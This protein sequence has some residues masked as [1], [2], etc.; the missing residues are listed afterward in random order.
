[1]SMY[2]LKMIAV[3]AVIVLVLSSCTKTDNNIPSEVSSAEQTYSASD[4]SVEAE[5][6]I[7]AQDF[8]GYEFK[9]IAIDDENSNPNEIWVEA[10]NGDILRDSIYFRNRAVEEKLNI[11][12]SSAM[13][14]VQ[15]SDIGKKIQTSIMTGENLFDIALPNLNGLNTILGLDNAIA[16]LES[17]PTLDLKADWWDQQSLDAISFKTSAEEKMHYMV[18]G[19]LNLNASFSLYGVLFNK[20]LISDYKLDSPYELVKSGKW[21]LDNMNKMITTVQSDL[22]G[23]GL[24][25]DNDRFGLISTNN[26]LKYLFLG[27]G[28]ELVRKSSDD[29]PELNS[30][31]RMHNVVERALKISANRYIPSEYKSGN[32][33]F[34]VFFAANKALFYQQS[35]ET[36]SNLRFM[37]TDF[38]ILPNPK[39]DESQDRYYSPL[40]A[41]RATVTIVPSA[42][43]D[44]NRTGTIMNAL[45]YYSSEY[46]IPAFFDVSIEGKSVRDIDSLEMIEIMDSSKIYSINDVFNFG[47]SNSIFTE[48]TQSGVN[49]F[50]SKL[51][52]LEVKI[53]TAINE[54]IESISK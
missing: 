38:G 32:D 11:K 41:S 31:E 45:G 21:T 42:N 37:D 16:V 9:A 10:E 29:L 3:A 20:S 40:A 15:R 33:A 47:N 2:K 23:D 22:N 24:M 14:G 35:L 8:D 13:P 27:T 1:M 46:V 52:S 36:V 7:P 34:R 30:S 39:F 28:E 54:Y 25:D 48:L 17:I 19:S 5:E 49:N 26:S 50:A 6:V 12:V 44:L 18:S 53:N 51:A 4:E 43:T